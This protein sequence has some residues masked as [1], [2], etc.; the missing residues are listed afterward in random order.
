MISYEM[1]NNAFVVLGKIVEGPE[2]SQEHIN[3]VAHTVRIHGLVSYHATELFWTA[4]GATKTTKYFAILVV[5][6]VEIKQLRVVKI[7]ENNTPIGRF[8][9]LIGVDITVR[10]RTTFKAVNVGH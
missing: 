10:N 9:L 5:L 3:V 6:W 1:L 2:P 8:E 4:I 7:I